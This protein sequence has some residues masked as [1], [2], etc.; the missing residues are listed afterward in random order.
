M[1]LDH[2]QCDL[3]ANMNRE[4]EQNLDSISRTPQIH[5]EDLL[6]QVHQPEVRLVQYREANVKCSS[7]LGRLKSLTQRMEIMEDPYVQH[8]RSQK[9][10]EARQELQKVI[11]NRKT[12]CFEELNSLE[13]M[14]TMVDAE[15]G[16]WASEF[17]I[18]WRVGRYRVKKVDKTFRSRYGWRG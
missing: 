16:P 13:H 11:H 7:L 17:Y 8:L 3:H 2:S 6:K 4:M 1:R 9:G 14:S 5:R 15:L 12:N 10:D 18:F